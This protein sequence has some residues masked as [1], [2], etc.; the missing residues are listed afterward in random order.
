VRLLR[1]YNR[2]KRSITIDVRTPEGKEIVYKLVKEIDVVTDNFRPGVMQ[3]LGLDLETLRKHNPLIITASATGFGELG[4]LADRPSFDIIGQGM[5]GIMSNMGGGPDEPPQTVVGGI[6]HQTGAMLL[7]LGI[8]GAIV[9]R[10]RQGVGQHVD[11]SLLGSQLALQGAHLVRFMRGRVQTPSPQRRNPIFAYFRASDG[12]SLTIGLLDPR[13]WPGLANTLERL[14]LIDDPRFVT[15]FDRPENRLELLPELDAA[16][17]KRERDDSL[18]L[19]T[20][21]SVPCGPVH[22]YEGA[23]SDPQALANDYITTLEHP[24]LGEVG[25]VGSP[26]RMSETPVRPR[27]TAPELGQHTE[28]LLLGLGYDWDKIATLK[29]CEVI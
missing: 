26:I 12:R 20:E 8:V 10:D 14:D 2:N 16:F 1:G 17:A 29:D 23:T 3:R 19:L 15:Q 18:D 6:A 28:E 5:G 21:A 11:S 25:V 24:S 9:A 13:W 4:P 27:H 7:A 22:D